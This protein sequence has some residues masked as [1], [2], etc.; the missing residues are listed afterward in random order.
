MYI[1]HKILLSKRSMNG[2]DKK[3]TYLTESR[4]KERRVI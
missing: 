1:I 2:K 4:V 3:Y